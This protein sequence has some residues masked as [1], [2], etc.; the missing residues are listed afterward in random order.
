MT[1]HVIEMT[2]YVLSDGVYEYIDGRRK[3]SVRQVNARQRRTQAH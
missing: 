3:A 1:T 2:R